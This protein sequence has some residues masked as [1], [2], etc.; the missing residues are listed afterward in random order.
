MRKIV[1]L[2]LLVL[3]A[4]GCARLEKGADKTGTALGK[5]ANATEKGL[6]KG[7]KAAEPGLNKTGEVIE[8]GVTRTGNWFE[9]MGDK[10][11]GDDEE[12]NTEE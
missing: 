4:G 2:T 7:A 8:R 3:L 9:R 5:A 11:F 6:T 12:D 10:L 1:T